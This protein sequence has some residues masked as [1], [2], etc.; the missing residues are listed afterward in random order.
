MPLRLK[1]SIASFITLA[2][3]VTGP[4]G[5][6][7]QALAQ[8][9]SGSV[10]GASATGVSGAAGVATQTGPKAMGNLPVRLDLSAKTV[11]TVVP[12]A[13]IAP[14]GMGLR[15]TAVSGSTSRVSPTAS[16]E[17]RAQ[18]L[19]GAVAVA[20]SVAA[21]PEMKTIQD[22]KKADGHGVALN[23]FYERRQTATA[24]SDDVEVGAVAPHNEVSLARPTQ[25]SGRARSSVSAPKA[26]EA[27]SDVG[28]IASIAAAAIAVILA[29]SQPARDLA[30]R[31][32]NIITGWATRGTNKAEQAS[33]DAEVD[34][35]VAALEAELVNL[36]KTVAQVGEQV[37]LARKERDDSKIESDRLEKLIKATKNAETQL[38]LAKQ[39]VEADKALVSKQGTLDGMEK[40]LLVAKKTQTEKYYETQAQITN[41][42]S[43]ASRAKMAQMKDR[44]AELKGNFKVAD[45]KESIDRLEQHVREMEARAEGKQGA[46]DNDPTNAVKDADQELRDQEAQAELDR[47]LGKKTEGGTTDGANKTGSGLLRDA[48]TGRAAKWGTGIGASLGALIGAASFVVLPEATL[49]A[50]AA[51]GFA[52]ASLGIVGAIVGVTIGAIAGVAAKLGK[53]NDVGSSVSKNAVSKVTLSHI[54][55]YRFSEIPAPAVKAQLMTAVETDPFLRKTLSVAQREG[56]VDALMNGFNA[57][58]STTE[59]ISR[60]LS[61]QAGTK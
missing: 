21:T 18:T 12:T 2:F 60:F 11:M 13:I 24:S 7:T 43:K 59:V 57:R 46:A 8:T 10:G 47:I 48:A 30:K 36:N 26:N 1:Q 25:T 17:S 19:A 44:M 54:D 28:T 50:F 38:G 29:V 37:S 31:W 16:S 41:L 9:Y 45:S 35:L 15:T 6:L 22:G 55:E 40:D 23:R 4:G 53:A 52:I 5:Q 14:Q 32:W 61:S 34:R 42:H 56:L 3:L 51:A 27:G 33:V 49:G 39:K 58:L 20:G